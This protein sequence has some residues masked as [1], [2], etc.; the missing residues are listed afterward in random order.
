M[1]QLALWRMVDQNT[2]SPVISPVTNTN[3][4]TRTE[5]AIK[6]EIGIKTEIATKTE[7]G[8][9][10]ESGIN[11]GHR[12][13]ISIEIVTGTVTAPPETSTR[14]VTV[15]AVITVTNM[16]ANIATI[17]PPKRTDNT[18]KINTPAITTVA[19]NTRQLKLSLLSNLLKNLLSLSNP[20]SLS[21]QSRTTT[22]TVGE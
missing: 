14:H 4:S 19:A 9:K 11:I 8:I 3:I 7:I 17:P 13:K 18:A 10:T 12:I 22:L 1:K 16:T 21:K 2:T 20:R 6:T 5:T 15:T